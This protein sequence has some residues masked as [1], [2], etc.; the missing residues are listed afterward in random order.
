MSLKKKQVDC[1]KQQAMN[2]LSM[3]RRQDDKLEDKLK[4]FV[5]KDKATAR[6]TLETDVDGWTPVHACA[7]KGSKHLLKVMIS[8]GID[9]NFRMGQP[10]GLP[11][12]CALLHI[13]AYRGDV[14]ICKYLISRGALV[15]IEDNY[16]RT[17]LYYAFKKQHSRVIELLKQK[18]GELTVE[19]NE[20][21]TMM[22]DEC[23]TPQ[24]TTLGFCFF[25][26]FKS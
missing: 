18:G 17:P 5:K 12:G 2:I 1:V 4:K 19:N 24:P 13:A 25:T 20:T 26:H 22:V 15:D 11:G 7:L 9:V 3:M 21:E 6:R 16:N 10:E 14:K 8:A 23:P